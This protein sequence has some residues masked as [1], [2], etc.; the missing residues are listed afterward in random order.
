M[1]T[2]VRLPRRTGSLA[3]SV[4]LA[5]GSLTGSAAAATTV[6]GP[7]VGVSPAASPRLGVSA[8]LS[9]DARYRAGRITVDLQ[10]RTSPE[11][12]STVASRGVS[13]RAR[14]VRIGLP[15]AQIKRW[16]ATIRLRVRLHGRK[17]VLA[18]S[19]TRV[20][21]QAPPPAAPSPVFDAPAPPASAVPI[22]T[23][24]T[25]PPPTHRPAP[26]PEPPAAYSG[27]LPRL[28]IA[29]RDGETITTKEPY[30]DA[31][32]TLTTVD[33]DTAY[34]SKDGEPDDEI[35]GRGNTT[36]GMP[37]KPYRLKLDKKAKLLG[38]PSSRHWALL[39]DWAD[40]SLLRNEL[41]LTLGARSGLTWTPR[42]RAVE[43]VMNGEYAGVY[44]LTEHVR[45]DAERVDIEV[46]APDEPAEASGYLIEHDLRL[47]SE[48]EVDCTQDAL[49][50][51]APGFVTSAAL[52]G[53]SSPFALKEPECYGPEQRDYIKGYVEALE[54]ALY[55]TDFADPAAGYRT[56]VDI[57]SAIDYLLIQELAQNPDAWFSSV[58]AFKPSAP[59]K[60]TMGPLWDFDLALGNYGRAWEPGTGPATPGVY[61][62]GRG[63]P[64]RMLQ[65]PWFRDATAE[66]WQTLRI[67]ALEL[68]P[69]LTRRA[70]D[71][72]A[73]ALQ[74]HR[75]WP[76]ET[77]FA[78]EVQA[79]RAWIADRIAW[80]DQQFPAPA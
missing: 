6:T 22:L 19:R 75:R 56:Y 39:A 63:W 70:D 44:H 72:A 27:T 73:A 65:D 34:D 62:G 2:L 61:L 9:V 76:R 31:R 64:G 32:L 16:P 35:K 8:R 1:Y 74:E 77:T 23:S 80:M 51:L 48:P 24:P 29:V 69:L 49:G 5:A 71:Y 28:E 12:W 13:G 42:T 26:E 54:A 53:V 67:A 59:G 47:G 58:F 36:W 79:V 15:I 17:Q 4:L 41:I 10:H 43:V 68:L 40:P 52:S 57:D 7:T 60:L 25:P 55:G 11:R 21:T 78:D 38:M 33:G 3:V 20:V 50:L 37:K 30:R 45:V 14:D 18:T 66:R 46:G